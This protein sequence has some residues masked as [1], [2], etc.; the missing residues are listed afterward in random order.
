MTAVLQ[1]F[2]FDRGEMAYVVDPRNYIVM[3]VNGAVTRRL[4][5]LGDDCVGRK[6]YELLHHRN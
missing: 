3:A 1:E 2:C 4:G 5:I 6:C